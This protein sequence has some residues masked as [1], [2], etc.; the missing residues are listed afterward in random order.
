MNVGIVGDPHEPASRAGYLDFC[1]DTFEEHEVDEV[2]CIGDLVDWHA[3]SFHARQPECP[4]PADEYHLALERVQRWATRFPKL[5]WTLGNHDERA[6]RLARTVSIPEFML[7]PY[8]EIWGVPDWEIGFD[9]MIDGVFYTHGTGTSGVHPAWNKMNKSKMSV[10]M[11][12]CHSRAG[13]KFGSN[14]LK[15]YFGLDVGCGVD[16]RTWQFAYGK[17]LD[18]RSMLAC[19]VVKDGWQPISIPMRC[20]RGEKYHDSRFAQPTKPLVFIGK[21][22]NK[23][24]LK[25]VAPVHL[26]LVKPGLMKSETVT[27]CKTE[28][29]FSVS[30]KLSEV[31]CGNCKRTRRYKELINASNA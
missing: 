6:A 30:P 19:A 23:A 17:N 26:A 29:T 11:G 9:F 4:G 7:K 24:N 16:D 31:T 3:V 12:H 22:G 1:S 5:K 13:V 27:A 8:N 20:S 2:V 28:G 10:V 18:E 15:R 25:R 21:F 14:R